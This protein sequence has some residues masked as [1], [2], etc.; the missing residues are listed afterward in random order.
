MS[1]ASASRDPAEVEVL[2]GPGASAASVHAQP[3]QSTVDARVGSPVPVETAKPGKTTEPAKP[4]EPSARPG[5]GA[6]PKG[7]APKEGKKGKRAPK[8]TGFKLWNQ[9]HD[10][11]SYADVLA[12]V[13]EAIYDKDP[14]RFGQEIGNLQSSRG[15][16]FAS[17]DGDTL[18][19]SRPVASTG[20]HIEVNFS[21][22]DTKKR[23][24][25]FLKAFGHDP[26]DLEVLY[27]PGASASSVQAQP[28]QST[29]DARAGSSAP[30]QT[31]RPS[32]E[33]TEPAKPAEPS[34]RPGGGAQ[35]TSQAPKE[36]KK[37]KRAPKPTGFKLWNQHH[38]VSSYA[39]VLAG[40]VE[41]IY[42]KDPE[43]FGQEIGNLQ[44]SRGTPFASKDGDTLHRSRPVASTGWH[45][46]V[47]FSAADTKKR[48]RQFLKAF[49]HDPGDLE[50]LY[51]PGASASS[52]QAQP[53]Q[54]TVDARV[55][56]PVP[57]ETA[58]PGKTTE[59]AKPAKP[60]ARSGGGAQPTS[61]APKKSKKG[62]R[63]PKPTGFE[64]WG[65]HHDASSYTDVLVGVVE[66]IHDRHPDTFHRIG[67]L[68]GTKRLWASKD[69]GDLITAGQVGSSHWHIE[70]NLSA[71]AKEKRARQY[72]EHFDY[73]PGDLEVLCGPGAAA[74]SV[75]AQPRQQPTR[76][77]GSPV[78]V[79][80]AKPGK[81]TEPAKPVK[82]PARPGGGAQ[83]TSQALK[84][85]K[86][87]KRAPKP[88]GFELWGE[89]HDASSYTDILVG[90]AAA[91][92][93][94]D[95]GRFDRKVEKLKSSRGKPYFS[96]NTDDF[97]RPK[98][99]K[100]S[101]LYVE[102]NLIAE[103]ALKRAR[104][105]LEH[106]GYDPGDLV[107]L[108]G[109]GAS[110]ASV[111]AQPRQQA[112]RG[113]GSTTP[114]QPRRSAQPRQQPTRREGSPVPVET[115]KPGKTTE[116]AKPAKPSAR[117]GGGAQPKGQ[118]PKKSKKGKRAPKPTGFKLWNQHHDVSSY[119]DVL[120]GVVEAIYDK[121]PERF[122][123]EVGGLRG[124]VRP[125]A[126]KNP[127]DLLRHRRVG[128][129]DWYVETNL[130]A[131]ATVKR[132]R[133][134]LEHF[135]YDPGDLVVLDGPGASA[136]SVQ[137]Q[138][139]QQA[140]RGAGS[141]TPAQPRRSAQ[142]RQQPTRRAGSSAP[143]QPRRSAQPPQRKDRRAG[144]PV[145]VETAKPGKTT[146]PAKPA[147]P[148]ARPGDG[149]QPTSQAP[150]KSKKG[151]GSPKPTGFELFGNPH[152]VG[153]YPDILV[154]VVKAVFDKRELRTRKERKAFWSEAEKLRSRQ[155][156]PFAVSKKDKN[157]LAKP[158]QIG[159][160]GWFVD[161]G[162]LEPA[163]FEKEAKR[164]L[165]HFK[166]EPDDLKVLSGSDPA[167]QDQPDQQL[168]PRRAK[169]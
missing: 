83:P 3:T 72:L 87:G 41:A 144:S 154:G 70:V 120:A 107:V 134:F 21:A 89:R 17:K 7:Q 77:E 168:K 153:S 29:V 53:P 135:G 28:P 43:R 51:G 129:S 60:S 76:R 47:N 15:T 112:T 124:R 6:Q 94:Q 143:A 96:K 90:V 165:E 56:S 158:R 149:A 132:A 97:T 11:S 145:P 79:E 44:S 36:G 68:R 169:R 98:R 136:A 59:P 110:A 10:V 19:R 122:D 130:D 4:A 115:A 82:P 162:D 81:T 42:D 30:A 131:A 163:Q 104:L 141:T 32:A 148:S 103:E 126:S 80:T 33:P 167:E 57:V 61:Q 105:F 40:V 116:P 49:G 1:A 73:D 114:A 155:G 152:K 125:F 45:I 108:D 50:V 123:R 52:V 54:S 140:T 27:G 34:A 109:P 67:E 133:R 128:G 157:K 85:G 78:P 16:P 25:Q 38:D 150:K 22:A 160:S 64:L 62:K 86:K 39:D 151:K 159:K 91:I 113:A 99:V 20:W 8:P 12:G 71:A 111:Q 142:P 147:K 121:D 161:I 24:R 88:T 93:Q 106:F 55:G 63:A 118:A 48:V 146:E 92:R 84:E 69:P 26:G 65:Q 66:A 35:P 13:V 102:A 119:A 23:V 75:Q 100:G 101:S 14:E 95:V 9:H 58:K 166:H 127:D 2:Y 31:R 156:N 74:A 138:P 5:G 46:E 18:H 164:F 117:P 37:G 139:R 137:A